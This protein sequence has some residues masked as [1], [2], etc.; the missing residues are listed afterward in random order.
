MTLSE[1][2]MEFTEANALQRHGITTVAQ[3]HAFVA[4][5]PNHEE[6]FG[7]VVSM[8]VVDFLATHPLT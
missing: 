3:L 4:A 2:G 5:H 8:A 1:A 7:R 6:T